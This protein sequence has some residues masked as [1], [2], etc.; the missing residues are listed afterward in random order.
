MHR[1][2]ISSLLLLL[3][4]ACSPQEEHTTTHK[5][6]VYQ[7]ATIK[8]LL[9]GG[10]D[11][12]MT[13]AELAQHGDFGIGTFNALDGEMVV[14][15]G[16]LYQVKTDGL[17]YKP[18]PDTKT[19]FAVMTHFRADTSFTISG[20]MSFEDLLNRLDLGIK[21]ENLFYAIRIDGEF[22]GLKTR[23]VPAQTK[24]YRP[25]GEV[26]EGQSV[27]SFESTEGSMVGFR[28]PEYTKEINVP[29][30]HLHYLNNE[31]KK[32]GHV[33]ALASATATVSIDYLP[34]LYLAL[35]ENGDFHNL[36]LTKDREEDLD[37]VEKLRN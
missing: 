9:E 5:D 23:S 27:F 31:R 13:L 17:A 24:P 4:Y 33:L 10:Y 7:Y 20:N 8:A 35:P 25:L 11:G 28:F 2:L 36:D 18:G 32:G 37:K 19:P 21:T 12:N 34:N 16:T 1:L 30:Y 6:E 14:M 3:I 26:V 15:D 29:G 22:T